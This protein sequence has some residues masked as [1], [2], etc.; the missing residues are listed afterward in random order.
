MQMPFLGIPPTVRYPC[1]QLLHPPCTSSAPPWFL[2]SSRTARLFI[3]PGCLVLCSLVSTHI[4]PVNWNCSLLSSFIQHVAKLQRQLGTGLWAHYNSRHG[5]FPHHPFFS[6]S[7]F[8]PPSPHSTPPHISLSFQEAGGVGERCFLNGNQ[9]EPSVFWADNPSGGHSAGDSCKLRWWP[10]VAVETP[11]ILHQIPA[12]LY[13]KCQEVMCTQDKAAGP[14][15]RVGRPG[16]EQ[17]E[18]NKALKQWVEAVCSPSISTGLNSVLQA[19]KRLPNSQAACAGEIRGKQSFNTLWLMSELPWYLGYYSLSR[20]REQT[21][22]CHPP[23]AGA[24]LGCSVLEGQAPLAQS[25]IF[26]FDPNARLW[27]VVRGSH[28]PGRQSWAGTWARYPLSDAGSCRLS[29]GFPAGCLSLSCSLEALHLLVQNLL[30]PQII[31]WWLSLWIGSAL[32][33]EKLPHQSWQLW[34]FLSNRLVFTK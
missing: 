13:R 15:R 24:N 8:L 7:F 32:R 28:C 33:L 23:K 26:R 11:E 17:L 19:R 21:G 14:G 31:H 30:G 20:R 6:L 22:H 12:T 29:A 10:H 9:P 4:L 27:S 1:E 5:S 25:G 34:H 3:V 16:E 18:L 2:K